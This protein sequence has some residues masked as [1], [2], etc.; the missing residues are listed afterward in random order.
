MSE[1]HWLVRLFPSGWRERYGDE[2]L[3][4]IEERR[5][6]VRDTLDIIVSAVDARRDACSE[7]QGFPPS[8]ALKRSARLDEVDARATPPSFWR[9]MFWRARF[10]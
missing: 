5:P 7:R 8:A 2:F 6:G 4:L 9:R 3:A 1:R 10:F